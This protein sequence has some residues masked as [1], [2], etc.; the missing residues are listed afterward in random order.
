MIEQVVNGAFGGN[1]VEPLEFSGSTRKAEIGRSNDVNITSM[2][3]REVEEIFRRGPR[4]ENVAWINNGIEYDTDRIDALAR[5]TKNISLNYDDF[6]WTS[7]QVVVYMDGAHLLARYGATQ[8][9]IVSPS[10]GCVA[11]VCRERRIGYVMGPNISKMQNRQATNEE[12]TDWQV[13]I[14]GTEDEVNP[15]WKT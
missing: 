7:Q 3:E 8:S 1:R 9:V 10:M 14:N 4:S 5:L 6:A 11:R 15:T 2:S 12:T 13:A